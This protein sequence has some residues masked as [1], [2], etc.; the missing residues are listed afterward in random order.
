[1][2]N[3][4]FICPYCGQHT[5]ITAPHEFNE[6]TYFQLGSPSTKGAVGLNI[7]AI[8]CPNIEC[9]KL[10]LE[11]ALT[12]AQNNV[13][14]Q[15]QLG[16]LN[17]L[18]KWQLLPESEARV[19]PEYIPEVIREDY[20]EA[21]RIRDLSPKASAT[22]ARRCLQGMIRDFHGITKTRLKDEIEEMKGKIDPVV[23]DAIDAVRSVGNVGA[24]MEKDINLVV[25]V[26]PGEAQ[27]LISLIESLLDDWYVLRHNRQEQMAKI[28]QIAATKQQTK[29]P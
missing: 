5:T 21:C 7:H 25:D 12:D 15:Y 10:F 27:A 4:N 14:T 1:M 2:S 26:D 29:Q 11:V 17:V 20:Y 23:W 6:W 28:K 8:S 9:K 16:P 19:L 13:R 22:L 3:K 24:H 18:E